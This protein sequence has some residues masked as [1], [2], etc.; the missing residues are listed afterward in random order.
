MGCVRG[1]A[2]QVLWMKSKEI[3]A[4][5]V[6]QLITPQSHSASSST[7]VQN[8]SSLAPFV[9][10]FLFDSCRTLK[11]IGLRPHFII[12]FVSNF[13]KITT[14]VNRHWATPQTSHKENAHPHKQQRCL[15]RKMVACIPHNAQSSAR[16][17][18]PT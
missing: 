10:Q 8:I 4:R 13:R 11:T 1:C 17:I 12:D 16:S 14:P 9:S 5:E 18:H 6:M 15:Y 7:N 2:A 3:G